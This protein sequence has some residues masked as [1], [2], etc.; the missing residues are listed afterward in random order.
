MAPFQIPH[1]PLMYVSFGALNHL[2]SMTMTL[3]S[4]ARLE[5]LVPTKNLYKKLRAIT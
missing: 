3:L 1:L 4:E 2:D 5:V